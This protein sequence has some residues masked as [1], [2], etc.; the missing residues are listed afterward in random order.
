VQY[1]VSHGREIS[2]VELG[3]AHAHPGR[4]LPILPHRH[5]LQPY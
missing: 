5:P 3:V 4:G 1:C 2:S